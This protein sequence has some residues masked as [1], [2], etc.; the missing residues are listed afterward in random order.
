M[1]KLSISIVIPNYNGIHL[2]DRNLPSVLAAATAYDQSTEVIVVDD[3]STDNSVDLLKTRFPEISCVVHEQNR[4]FAEAVHSGVREATGQLC[5]LLNSD[6]QPDI[7]CLAPLAAYFPDEHV[8]AVS[9]TI[10]N[11]KGTVENHSWYA[12]EF[13]HGS[14]KRVPWNLPDAL[15]ARKNGRLPHLYTSG[16]SMLLPKTNFEL[17]GGFHPLYKPFYSEDVDLGIRAWR[18]GLASYFEPNS[19]VIHQSQGSIKDAFKLA[20]VKRIRKRN[21]YLLEWVHF[22]LWRLLTQSLPFTLVQLIGELILLDRVN[23]GGFVDALR[24]IDEVRTVRAALQS[25]ECLTMEQVIKQIT[26]TLRH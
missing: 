6:V 15:A 5:F 9:P 3:G 16:G 14:L 7:N 13:R 20:L 24:R 23:I 1:S 21:K 2:L 22:P 12:A 26:S 17:M 11:E 10:F 18:R 25:E 4:G 8:F 19:K